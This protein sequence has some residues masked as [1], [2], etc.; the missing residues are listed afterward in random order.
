MLQQILKNPFTYVHFLKVDNLRADTTSTW[1][2]CPFLN[3]IFEMYKGF[4]FLKMIWQFIPQSAP[5]NSVVFNSYVFVLHLLSLSISL[6]IWVIFLLKIIPSERST[7][8]VQALYFNIR[9]WRNC[10]WIFFF[11]LKCSS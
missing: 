2:P 5:L 6:V 8:V 3:F 11:P 4:C 9:I 1:P 10:V 7:C